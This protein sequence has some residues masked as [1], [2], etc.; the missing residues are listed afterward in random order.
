MIQIKLSK[1]DGRAL[2]AAT[3]AMAAAAI[4][5]NTGKK[6]RDSAKKIIERELLSKRQVTLDTLPDKE[7]VMIQVDGKDVLKIERKSSM[8]L[9]QSALS[10]A[11]PEIASQFTK[12][13][14]ASYFSSLIK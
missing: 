1:E 2:E 12:P 5:E 8:R 10:E 7:I 13:S 3:E 6:A 9:D 4:A 14:V 11:Q